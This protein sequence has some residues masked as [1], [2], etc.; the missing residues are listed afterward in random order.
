LKGFSCYVHVEIDIILQNPEA[1]RQGI[2]SYMTLETL[3]FISRVHM[4]EE[5]NFLKYIE[6]TEVMPVGVF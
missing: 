6:P 3:G 1:N 2:C 4:V 5:I